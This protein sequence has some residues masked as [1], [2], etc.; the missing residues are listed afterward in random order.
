MTDE[1]SG[2]P[3]SI[4]TALELGET[5]FSEGRFEEAQKIFVSILHQDPGHAD[6][7]NNL[8]VLCQQNGDLKQAEVLFL[9]AAALSAQPGPIFTNLS[10][11]ALDSGQIPAATGYL[12]RALAWMKRRV[13]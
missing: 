13:F 8:A 6:A 11:V 9:R 10:A 1:N 4:E 2:N 7:L 3:Q 5:A 12:E